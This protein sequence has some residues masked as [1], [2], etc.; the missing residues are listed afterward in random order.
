MLDQ[1]LGGQSALANL[2]DQ[3]G[4][5]A[6]HGQSRRAEKESSKA[7]RVDYSTTTESHYS[8]SESDSIEDE[9]RHDCP[10]ALSNG[11]LRKRREYG[12]GKGGGQRASESSRK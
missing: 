1:I 7:Q 2:K 11:F 12:A 8:P 10:M 5:H 9:S 3:I 4:N 6:H